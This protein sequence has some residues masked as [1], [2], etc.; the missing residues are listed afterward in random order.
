MSA[1]ATYRARAG[2]A[3][4][5]RYDRGHRDAAPAVLL[6]DDDALLRRLLVRTLVCDGRFRLLE[7]GSAI[8][9]LRIAREAEPRLVLLDIRLGVENGLRV[10]RTLKSDPATRRIRV[11]IVSAQA[12]P[13]TRERARQACADLFFAK[14]FSPLGLW[15]AVDELLAAS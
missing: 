14:P 8:E 6:I 13:P 7:A 12:D 9:G 2:V 1:P 5:G 11:V 3:A 10:C 15:K 4:P